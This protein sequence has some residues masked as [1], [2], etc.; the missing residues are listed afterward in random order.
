MIHRLRK[1]TDGLFRGSGPSP[2]DVLWLKQQLGIRKIVSLD[3]EAGEKIDRACKLLHINH[4]KMYLHGD[5]KSLLNLLHHNLKDLLIDGGPTYVHCHAGKDRTGLV[6]ALFKCKYMG[7]NPDKAIE[8][9]KSLGF[10][11][12]VDP[13]LI[14][15]YERL[16]RSCKVVKDQ[17]NADIVSNER[18]N[19][20]DNRDSFLD[21]VHRGD[22]SVQLDHTRQNPM[23]ALYPYTLDQSPTREN[24]PDTSLFQHDPNNTVTVPNV[25][26]YDNDAGQRGFGPVERMDGFFSEVGH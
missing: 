6:V 14:H 8:E 2:K 3:K 15:L 25:G 7:M 19:V 1:V 23:D 10:G 9:A 20:G 12:G 5:R 13:K 26:E 11:I 17:N 22:F 21:E 16:I 18:E 4:V 24:Y